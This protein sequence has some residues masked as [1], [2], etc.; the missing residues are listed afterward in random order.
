MGVALAIF[1]MWRSNIVTLVLGGLIAFYGWTCLK[2]GIFG[3]KQLID[4][5]TLDTAANQSQ[6]AQ[7]EW[8]QIFRKKL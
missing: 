6:K 2:I 4:E 5:M 7:E 8:E 3:S 1:V